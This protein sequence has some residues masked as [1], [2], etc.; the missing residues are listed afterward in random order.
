[1]CILNSDMFRAFR[2][3]NKLAT[4]RRQLLQQEVL[5]KCGRVPCAC[6]ETLYKT[7]A[8]LAPKKYQR[9]KKQY[10]DCYTSRRALL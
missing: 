3:S 7:D 9:L 4:I 5:D 6:V 1:M 8:T 2:T 10:E